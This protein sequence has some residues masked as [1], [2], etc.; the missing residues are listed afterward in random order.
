MI[1]RK[2]IFDDPFIN[3]LTV[4]GIRAGMTLDIFRGR[5]WEGYT[6]I[7]LTITKKRYKKKYFFFIL[8]S[9]IGIIIL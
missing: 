5:L 8:F 2:I 6:Q 4:S 9:I 3:M 1:L 7:T